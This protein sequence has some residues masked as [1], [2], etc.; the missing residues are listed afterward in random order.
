MLKRHNK[1]SF[2][3]LQHIV[4]LDFNHMF[5]EKANHS[6]TELNRP[7]Y[8]TVYIFT[9]GC[10][11]GVFFCGCFMGF[12]KGHKLFITIKKINIDGTLKYKSCFSIGT[13][14]FF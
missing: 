2:H 12:T 14:T 8:V 3:I 13:N 4:R 11:L 9:V 7:Y 10:S 6:L 1:N 5:S